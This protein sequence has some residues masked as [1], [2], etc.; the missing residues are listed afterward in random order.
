MDIEFFIVFSSPAGSTGLVAETIDTCFS[1]HDI[2]ANML[3]L[4]KGHDGSEFTNLIRAAKVLAV[5]SMM[6]Q[7]STPAGQ[8]HPNKSDLQ[9]DYLR[10]RL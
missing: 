3:D 7:S 9:V 4:G 1:R 10:Q 8:G 5:H 6:W 2:E